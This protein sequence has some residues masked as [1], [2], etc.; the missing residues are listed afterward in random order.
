M[1]PPDGGN[2]PPA[3]DVVPSHDGTR[4]MPDLA[5]ILDSPALPTL[6]ERLRR[7]LADEAERR[8]AFRETLEGEKAEFINGEVIVHSPAR[9]RHIAATKRILK[10]LDT[11]V[12][13]HDLGWVGVEKALVALTRNDY[14]PDVCFFGREK[15]A[16]IR[17][18]TLEF[19]APDLVV[20]VLSPSTERRDRGVKFED[21]AAHGVDE[22]WIVDAERETV[23]QYLLEGEAYDLA[24]KSGTGT[25]AA[26]SV[27]GFAIPVRA[28][29]DDAANLDALRAILA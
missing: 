2:V 26:R 28:V 23:E 3:R 1:L 24:M 16:A 13:V 20:E 29:F 8:A 19:P 4:A 15:A 12:Q 10:L 17:P 21:Y 5:P 25:L 7:T 9:A 22:Y 6:V 11:Y 14:E 18:E 27:E